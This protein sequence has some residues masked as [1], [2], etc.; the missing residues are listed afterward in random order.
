[1]AEII[2]IEVLWE[3]EPATC[4]QCVI[5]NELIFSSSHNMYI[6]INEK[7]Y[8]SAITVCSSCYYLI[9]EDV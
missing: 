8:Y 9:K 4:G 2:S 7:K 1:M 6:I 5:C 3:K